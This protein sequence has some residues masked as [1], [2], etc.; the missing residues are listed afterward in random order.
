[1]RASFFSDGFQNSDF[2]MIPTAMPSG[3]TKCSDKS[4]VSI[5]A[6]GESIESPSQL[7]GTM[8][9]GWWIPNSIQ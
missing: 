6:S 3:S 5:E 1:M 2:D 7:L 4:L 8:R 9:D